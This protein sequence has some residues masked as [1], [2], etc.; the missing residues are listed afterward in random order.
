MTRL[1]GVLFACLFATAAVAGVG[2]PPTPNNG[3]GLVDGTWLNGLAGGQN[4]SYQAG[5][6]AAGTSSHATSTQLPAGIALIEVDTVAANSGVSLPPAV[7]GTSIAVFNSTATT[8]TVYPSI[9]NNP[10]TGSQDTI[11]GGASFSA[12][13]ASGGTVSVFICAKTGVW[14]AK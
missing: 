7:A 4:Q 6:A 10:A 11:N 9:S 14:G 12:T 3:P 5:I 8:L 13:G 1:L 2:N